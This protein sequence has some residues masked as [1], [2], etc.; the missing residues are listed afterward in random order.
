MTVQLNKDMFTPTTEAAFCIITPTEYLEYYAPNSGT[1]LV[2]AHL[3]DSDPTYAAFYKKLSE[4]G[5][6]LMMDCSAFE[7]GESYQP[8][9]LVDLGK[10]CGAHAVV[11]PDY[12]FAPSVKTID[13][14]KKSIPRFKDAGFATFF[15]PQ[16]ETGKLSDW[17]DGYLWAA[18]NPNIDII[19]MS[20]LGIPN[21]MPHIPAAYARVVMTQLLIDRGVFANKYHHYLG[22]N[23]APN[24]E[25]PSLLKMNALNSCDSSNPV[26]CGINGIH[27]NET[28]ADFMGIQKKYLRSVDFDEPLTKKVHI[29]HCIQ[30]NVNV[31]LDIFKNPTKYL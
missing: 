17:I 21:A 26:W 11:L 29:H 23:S 2:L 30:H 9:R 4:E 8:T 31:T 6:R 16:S 13:A 24:V 27:Y 22:L 25:L 20:I 1:H 15:V 18:D 10:R 14:A 28:Y 19:G 12:P 3:V 5:H 7:L